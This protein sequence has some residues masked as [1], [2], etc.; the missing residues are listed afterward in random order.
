MD[1]IPSGSQTQLQGYSN[2]IAS[3]LFPLLISASQTVSLAS[4]LAALHSRLILDLGYEDTS[5]GSSGQECR[6]H[7]AEHPRLYPYLEEGG[8]GSSNKLCYR[9]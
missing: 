9:Q 2:S 7:V 8:E 3:L 4:Y 6:Y 1:N 5:A